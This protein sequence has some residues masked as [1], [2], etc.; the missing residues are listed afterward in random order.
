M[1][2]YIVI[3]PLPK[4]IQEKIKNTYEL[5]F[6]K[7]LPTSYLHLT[8]LSP[9]SFKGE[10]SLNLLNEIL[11]KFKK[12]KI[13]ASFSSPNLFRNPGETILYLPVE[14]EKKIKKVY[15][16]LELLS[17]DIVKF[18]TSLYHTDEVPP[19]LAHVSL[20]YNFIFNS[21]TLEKLEKNLEKITFE[22]K[23][24]IIMVKSASGKWKTLQIL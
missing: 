21:K 7:I 13:K 19:F 12:T 3:F 9:F 10:K 1:Q 6:N 4:K 22:L 8:L 17:K 16:K 5:T 2:N 18:E 23:K 14:P 15:D 24:P 11:D 20:D